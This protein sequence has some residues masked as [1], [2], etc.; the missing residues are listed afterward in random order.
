MRRV[1]ALVAALL[2]ALGVIAW[3]A[4]SP[5]TA[6]PLV[7]VQGDP[8]PILPANV[9]LELVDA[10]LVPPTTAEEA[11]PAHTA[12]GE[13]A[14][15]AAAP[16]VGGRAF[17]DVLV[18]AAHDR[19]PIGGAKVQASWREESSSVFARS[20]AERTTDPEGRARLDVEP[21]CQVAVFATAGRDAGFARA[22]VPPLP[23]GEAHAVEL[24]LPTRS[25]RRLAGSVL[26]E[27]DGAP[28]AG[29]GVL[30]IDPERHL[31]RDRGYLVN[32]PIGAPFELLPPLASAV[33][34][35]LGRFEVDAAT[36]KRASYL[37]IEA[38]GRAVE[39]RRLPGWEG[40]RRT[41]VRRA[42]DAPPELVE[43]DPI[44]LARAPTLR[45]RVLARDAQPVAGVVV[46][47]ALDL[48]TLPPSSRLPTN[49]SLAWEATTG[50]D[51]A[52]E[53]VAL[54]VRLPFALELVRDGRVVRR[55]DALLELAPGETRELARTLGTGAEVRGVLVDERGQPL[56]AI[57]R[58]ALVPGIAPLGSGVSPSRRIAEALTG[59]NGAF[60]FADVPAGTWRIEASQV[61]D[62]AHGVL[63]E[64]VAIG[65][66]VSAVEV[67]VRYRR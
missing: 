61:D 9:E 12:S 47:A 54:P 53:L 33:C 43:L 3:L 19:R 30:A 6:R 10:G 32:G 35:E 38:P 55:D 42:P 67:R 25:D 7:D 4:S 44:R 21:G 13:R 27:E 57:V 40:S 56:R 64:E 59:R 50:P 15:A 29:A 18:L 34:D 31:E 66:G 52:C 63:P 36:W 1:V 48:R 58:L 17:V 5:R 16:R 20:M 8:A 51:G 60:V 23:E 37:R 26:R 45:V 28:I 2:V 24:L 22:S 62:A 14:P 41:S 39:F 49:P 11:A 65:E 46:R